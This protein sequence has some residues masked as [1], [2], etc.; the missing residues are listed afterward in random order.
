MM[1][2]PTCN[3]LR[4]E[5]VD[6]YTKDFDTTA[7]GLVETYLGMQVEQLPGIIR[8]HLNYIR[9]TWAEYKAFQMKS[10]QPKLVPIQP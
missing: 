1:H 3:A 5:F 2:I 9:E 4:Q 6:K 8:R 10:L 7:G